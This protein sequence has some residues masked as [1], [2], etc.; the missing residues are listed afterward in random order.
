MKFL[1]NVPWD[2]KDVKIQKN[3]YDFMMMKKFR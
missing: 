1:N 3:Q 2:L